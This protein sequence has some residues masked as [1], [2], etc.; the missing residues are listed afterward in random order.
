MRYNKPHAYL[1]Y[2]VVAYG[3]P[4]NGSLRWGVQVENGKILGRFLRPA[5][6]E[7]MA[8]ELKRLDEK[9]NEQAA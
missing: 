2:L 1:P 6:A 8:L 5:P 7:R 4:H 9:V 3:N